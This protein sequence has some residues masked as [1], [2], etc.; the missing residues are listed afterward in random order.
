MP[1]AVSLLLPVAITEETIP[2]VLEPFEVEYSDR[3]GRGTWCVFVAPRDERDVHVTDDSEDLE[4][5]PASLLHPV[6]DILGSPP[7][8]IVTLIFEPEPAETELARQIGTAFG[9]Y[10]PYA[11]WYAS[12]TPPVRMDRPAPAQPPPERGLFAHLFGS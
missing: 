5:M 10:W 12:S 8:A 7:M 2:Q 6:T 4:A 1:T 11:W 9:E 3:W